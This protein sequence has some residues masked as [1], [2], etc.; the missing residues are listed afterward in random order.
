MHDELLTAN[1]ACFPKADMKLDC[2]LSKVFSYGNNNFSSL[3][4]TIPIDVYIQSKASKT[5]ESK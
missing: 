2:F 3:I 4:N 1:H 5:C